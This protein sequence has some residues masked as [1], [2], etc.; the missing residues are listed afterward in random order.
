MMEGLAG[1]AGLELNELDAVIKGAEPS[2]P[3]VRQLAP[4][5]GIH[6]ADIFVL[7][8]LSLPRDLATAT[9]SRSEE[10]RRRPTTSPGTNDRTSRPT[11]SLPCARTDFVP[12][13]RQMCEQASDEA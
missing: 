11:S 9:T 2:Q 8:G 5:L 3:T 1:E 4:A 10:R 12:F 7:A 13:P 6:A